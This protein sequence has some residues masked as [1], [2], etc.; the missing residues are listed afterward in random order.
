[1]QEALDRLRQLSKD[2]MRILFVETGD[3]SSSRDSMSTTR[4]EPV[5][6]GDDTFAFATSA[7]SPERKSEL[8]DERFTIFPAPR[9]NRFFNVRC[10][11]LLSSR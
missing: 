7:K 1:M 10:T 8:Y 2:D 3:E 9:T 11:R 4:L 5:S 6:G